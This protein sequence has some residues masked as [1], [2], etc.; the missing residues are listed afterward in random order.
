MTL[1]LQLGVILFAARLGHMVFARFRLPGVLG[2][3]GAGMLIGPFLL[4][5]LP[6]PGYPAG[7]F[8]APPEAG[9]LGVP[10]SPELYGISALA[11]VTLL[12]LAGL[13]TDARM[14]LRHSL[15]SALAGLGGVVVSFFAGAGLTAAL[16]ERLFGE[17][18]GWFSP[19]CMIVGVIFTATSV[20]LASRVLS[21]RGRI[22]GP[23]G[24]SI[25]AA[26]VIDDVLG[27]VLLAVVLGVATLEGGTDM[28]DALG[29]AGRFALRAVAVWLGA[30]A[31]GLAAARWIGA[32][33]KRFR[34][35][36]VISVMALALALLVAGL[37]EAVGL[38]MIVGAYVAGLTLSRTDLRHVALERLH[39]LHTFLVPVFFAVMGMLVDV[40]LLY[41]VD[42]LG[43]GLLF[44][45]AALLAKWLGCGLPPLLAGFTWQGGARIGAGMVP[46]GEVALL[47]AGA[48]MVAGLFEPAGLAVVV[49][50]VVF[51]MLAAPPLMALTFRGDAPGLR[52]P[53]PAGDEREL[54]FPFPSAAAVWML[55]EKLVQAF[56]AE[57][58]FVHQ[59]DRDRSL[60]QVRKDRVVIGF[61]ATPG[62]IVF[63]CPERDVSFVRT[64]M[65]EVVADLEHTLGDLRKPLDL[66][67][68]QRDLASA[69]GAGEPG[70]QARMELSD[71]LAPALLCPRL[72]ADTRN[73]AIAELLDRVCATG[74]VRDRREALR[75][76][77]GREESLSTGLQHGVAVP[78]A[79][80]D[81]VDR[82]VCAIGLKPGG[83]D[84]GAVDGQPSTIIVLTLAPGRAG[85]PY[86]QFMSLVG[87]VLNE[88]GRAAL[89]ACDTPND[90]YG[91]LA[92]N[93][94]GSAAPRRERRSGD[95]SA[96]W[97]P[98]HIVLDLDAPNRDAAIDAL[99]GRFRKTG[100]I[101]D[102]APVRRAVLDRE[103]TMTTAVGQG[104][105]LPHARVGGVSRLVTA[106]AVLRRGV[107]F[108]APDGQPVD[109]V[110]LTLVP[111]AAASGYTRFLATLLRSLDAAGREALRGAKS[112][113]DAIRVLEGLRG[114][115]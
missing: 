73:G 97:D 47:M 11:G 58:F 28:G 41:R 96:R 60:Y 7:L 109:L 18:L 24:S 52:R 71:Y 74:A 15:A 12:F 81:A 62:A 99:L 22:D 107:D 42:Q 101:R 53:S 72:K 61:R 94:T 78:H 27:M 44:F 39:V 2:E 77:L 110:A 45:A 105:A 59:L 67:T 5:G 32:G 92:G 1:M 19:Q 88:A 43:Y 104:L 40:R 16:S 6:L 75:A 23:E 84:F 17:T 13:D 31:L 9:A 49:V 65:R 54:A 34:S 51:T 57:G 83:V 85:V 21:D 68:L 115:R 82:L 38:A 108:D 14:L 87:Q 10:V 80:T 98:E 3:L 90:M 102:L 48:G 100:A 64:A 66:E 46:R 86:L 29:S 36:S 26:A 95:E 113:G 50:M 114:I 56:E 89:L 111:P 106:L 20:G 112:R 63:S 33:L 70:A 37:F 55:T 4:G 8:G 91:V 30:T 79:R 76:V 25:L 103:R 35:R 93:P 69:D